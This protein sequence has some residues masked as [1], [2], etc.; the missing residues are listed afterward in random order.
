MPSS[1]RGFLLISD[2]AGDLGYRGAGQGPVPRG[3]NMWFKGTVRRR[4]ERVDSDP[5]AR[6]EPERKATWENRISREQG[7]R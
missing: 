3:V 5:Q 4:G 1:V 2:P 7:S 6:A